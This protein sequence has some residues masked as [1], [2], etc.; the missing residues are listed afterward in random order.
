MSSFSRTADVNPVTQGTIEKAS[1]FFED[2]AALCGRFDF[3]P[4]NMIESH[5][6]IL[7]SGKLYKAYT[8]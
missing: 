6:Q 4:I 5:Q 1:H 7:I 2:N 3:R 8:E